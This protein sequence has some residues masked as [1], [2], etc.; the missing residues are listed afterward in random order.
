[1]KKMVIVLMAAMVSSNS[2]AFEDLE[3]TS[4]TI[5]TEEQTTFLDASTPIN[6]CSYQEEDVQGIDEYDQNV[7][8]NVTPPKVSTTEAM[9]KEMLGAVL[10]RYISLREVAREYFTEAKNV[11]MQWY[12]K[13][14]NAK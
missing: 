9:F 5:I 10:V 7:T 3:A 4:H 1:M 12:Q 8:D 14:V 6:A 11:V 2:S 13:I